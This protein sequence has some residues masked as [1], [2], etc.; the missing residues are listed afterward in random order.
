MAS[1]FSEDLAE[2]ARKGVL[3]KVSGAKLLQ[4]DLSEAWR[5]TDADY[6]T[7]AMRF[8]VMD[9]MVDRATGAYIS[10]DRTEPSET[11]EIWTFTRRAGGG[12]EEWKLSAIQ[13]V[14]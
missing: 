6:A 13:Q 5:E 9:T 4:G 2:N 3:N 7:V 1:Y 14:A 8:S 12:M 10:G 11:T